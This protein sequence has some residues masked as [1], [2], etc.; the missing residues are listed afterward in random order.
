MI[1]DYVKCLDLIPQAVVLDLGMDPKVGTWG[2]K[3]GVYSW[4][5]G[6]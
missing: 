4:H 1:T 5:S 3:V 2:S 6:V